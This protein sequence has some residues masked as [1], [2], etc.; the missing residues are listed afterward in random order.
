MGSLLMARRTYIAAA[1]T[2]V[3]LGC[4]SDLDPNLAGRPCSESGECLPG[5]VCSPARLCVAEESIAASI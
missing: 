3:A 2:L 4:N 1:L 5:Y